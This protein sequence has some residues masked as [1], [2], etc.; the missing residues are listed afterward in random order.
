[1]MKI[2]YTVEPFSF[3][4]INQI[5]LLKFE[6]I[7]ALAIIILALLIV[8]KNISFFNATI[9]SLGTSFISLLMLVFETQ[10]KASNYIF[11]ACNNYYMVDRFSQYA[12]LF[13][14]FAFIIFLFLS[15]VWDLMEHKRGDAQFSLNN[16]FPLT[17]LFGLL[18]CYILISSND[19]LLT[20]LAIEGNTAVILCFMLG[21]TSIFKA[22]E[23]AKKYFII[24]G[25][26][27]SFMLFGISVVFLNCKTVNYTYLFGVLMDPIQARYVIMPSIFIVAGILIKIAAAP[28]H[29]WAIE[30][31]GNISFLT[32]IFILVPFKISLLCV[33]AK[34]I[35]YVFLEIKDFWS[36]ILIILGL[37]SIFSGSIGALYEDKIK[38]F[39]VFGSVNQVGYLLLALSSINVDGFSAF[40]FYLI[41]YFISFLGFAVFLTLAKT[42][43]LDNDLIF[44]SQLRTLKLPLTMFIA[45]IPIIFSMMGFPPFMGFLSKYYVLSSVAGAGA[46]LFVYFLLVINIITSFYYLRIVKDLF[47]DNSNAVKQLKEIGVNHTLLNNISEWSDIIGSNKLMKIALL[48]LCILSGAL[49]FS[50]FFL[51]T[52]VD[53]TN[54]LSERVLYPMSSNPGKQNFYLFK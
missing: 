29:F 6:S 36:T 46:P 17:S 5:L 40:F 38:K 44:I 10:N 14:T 12:K 51:D 53:F 11:S 2:L 35:G 24:S 43:N 48:I 37:I 26:G 9:F 16:L 27:T 4:F 54:I 33:L 49:V 52:I 18:F 8:L 45:A 3:S 41:F 19:L 39:F 28:F 1:M 34:I 50:W 31:Y 7:L 15:L 22:T 25:T 20:Y 32:F 30:I 23:A 21:Y 42:L 13:L 47:F